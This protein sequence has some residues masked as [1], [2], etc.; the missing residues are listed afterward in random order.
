ML[1]RD[2]SCLRPRREL[3]VSGH[4]VECHRRERQVLD[5]LVVLVVHLLVR[6]AGGLHLRTMEDHILRT[7][8]LTA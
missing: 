3:Q 4:L 7:G 6:M 1:D 2:R 5:R 8:R